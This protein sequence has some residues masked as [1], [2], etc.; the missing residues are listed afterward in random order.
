MPSFRDL[1]LLLSHAA[2][3]CQSFPLLPMTPL[4]PYTT[5][6]ALRHVCTHCSAPQLAGTLFNKVGS[7]SDGRQAWVHRR[8]ALRLSYAI[9]SYRAVG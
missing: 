5:A 3:G 8:W 6:L 7:L 4:T 2:R 1:S 9:A